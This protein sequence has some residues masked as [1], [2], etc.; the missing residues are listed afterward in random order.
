MENFSLNILIVE[1]DL[2]LAIDLE[3]MV[4]AMGYNVIGKT[5]N[6]TD[7]LQIIESQQPDLVLMDIE[8][9]GDLTGIELA[10]K[11]RPT[12]IPVLFITGFDDQEHYQR[13]RQTNNI[14]YLIK[15]VRKF[16]LHAA[17]ETAFRRLSKETSGKENF[18]HKNSLFFKKRGILHR[19]R[20]PSILFV[21][22]DDDYTI[23]ETTKGRFVS[24]LRLFEMNQMLEVFDFLKVHRS[25]VVNLHK[26]DQVDTR[27]NW[28]KIGPHSIPVSRNN[29]PIVLH[30]LESFK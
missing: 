6:A 27:N 13:A 23:V 14:G 8:I 9:K 18:S 29:K 16:T 22:A 5:D 17:I 19:I 4:A 28:L 15:P 25:H 1:D 30:K 7:A 21:S 11:I 12:D 24:S 3:M 20:I 2:T 26:V 10:E